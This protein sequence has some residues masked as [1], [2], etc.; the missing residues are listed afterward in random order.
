MF[1]APFASAPFGEVPGSKSD[2]GSLCGEMRDS[3]LRSAGLQVSL[4]GNSLFL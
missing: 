4:V 2:Q 1:T 3:C